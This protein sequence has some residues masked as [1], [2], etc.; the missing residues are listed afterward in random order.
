MRSNLAASKIKFPKLIYGTA[1]KKDNT[2]FLVEKA[3][4]LGFRAI[5]TAC[6]PKH[7]NESAVGIAIKNS[8]IKREEIFLQTKFTPL[9]GHDPKKIPYNPDLSIEEQ[10]LQSFAKSQANLCTKYVDSLILHSPFSSTKDTLKAWQTMETIHQDG[11]ARNI[12]ISN[13]YDTSILMEIHEQAKVKP[14]FLQNRFYKE[15][16]YD[17]DLRKWCSQNNIYYQGFW[18]LTA[19]PHIVNS[20][21]I[22]NISNK[23]TKT[24]EQIYFKYL[25]SQEIIP[26]VGSCSENHI[27]ES[28]DIF[29]INLSES[30]IERINT[31]F[32]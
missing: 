21:T 19:N 32:N 28:L 27:K 17:N 26:L 5:D 7:Y 25:L 3:L 22:I 6:Q 30:E 14:S 4:S 2:A 23:H 24:P 18:T 8:Q 29:N 13:C 12:G 15:T 11:G 9:S 1:W 16:N 20:E 31:L 10:V